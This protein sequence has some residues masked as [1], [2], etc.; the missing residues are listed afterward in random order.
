MIIS[1]SRG[2]VK[3]IAL[4]LLNQVK[5]DL[6]RPDIK[7]ILEMCLGMLITGSSN[8]NLIAGTLK[9]K[10]AVK[11]TLK[12][13]QRMLLNPWI[14][15]I[16]NQLSLK[17]GIKKIDKTT[18]IALD[19]GD[20]SHQYGKSYEK[21]CQVRDG[22]SGEIR[23]GYWL[24]QV[25]GYNP[26]SKET[27]P[28]L[29][30]IYSTEESGFKSAT[31]ESIKIVE[32]LVEE[33]GDKGLWVVDRGYDGGEIL[34]YFLGKGLDFML[35]MRL[36]KGRNIIYRGK[37]INISEVVEIIN[38]RV[39]YGKNSRFGSMK[40]VIELNGEEYPITVV[41]YKDK[42]N[43]E[44][45]VFM[46]NGWIKSTKELKRRIKGYF[47]RWGVEECYRFEK[48]GFGIE[49]SRS[50][51]YDRIKTLLGLTIISW[52]I[53]IRVN[54]EPKLKEVVLKEARMEKDKLKDR[55]KFIY[56]RLI[57]G[58]RNMFLGVKRI[59]LF[60]LKRQERERVRR[61]MMNQI[62]LFRDLPMGDFLD[63]MWLGEVA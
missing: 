31:N 52:M 22:S 4:N 17:E 27:Y 18:I 11:Y 61:E 29:L 5:S 21:S 50:R 6:N 35:R 1:T 62:S 46:T 57:R 32:K 20:I 42:R 26:G 59:F 19:G 30:S 37:K 13:L 47:R 25:S 28:I 60:R 38:R 14:L 23:T 2:K 58:I 44:P 33:I 45:M 8:V 24:N 9:E 49:E 34:K 41:C 12:R 3:K 15:E 36:N 40:A 63:Y 7:F 43:K 53:L 48:Q 51:N 39:K 10:I 56:Y 55:P 16:A 54:E